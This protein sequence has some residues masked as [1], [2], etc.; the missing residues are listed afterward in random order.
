MNH[1][2]LSAA[3]Y[4][5][6]FDDRDDLLQALCYAE[7]A[8]GDIGDAEREPGDDLEWCEKR[9]AEALPRIREL[10][11][12]Y[13]KPTTALK[14]AFL[15]SPCISAEIPQGPKGEQGIPGP[16]VTLQILSNPK[17]WS[18][19]PAAYRLVSKSDGNGVPVTFLQG[20]YVWVQGSDSGREW[21]DLPTQDDLYAED[22]IPF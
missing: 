4:S 8:L 2:N 5:H 16:Q 9:A 10:M 22:N 11:E 3:G 21:R 20:L 13:G 1:P 12:A 14:D 18:T 19:F 7:A 6:A 15:P 17:E